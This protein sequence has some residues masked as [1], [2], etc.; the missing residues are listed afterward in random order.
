MDNLECLLR[1][2]YN[3]SG[4][5]SG[6]MPDLYILLFYILSSDFWWADSTNYLF[7]FYL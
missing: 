2:Y 7:K 4:Y 6:K 3:I 1:D 5:M